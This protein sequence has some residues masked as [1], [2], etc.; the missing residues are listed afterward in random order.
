[1][2]PKK[3]RKNFSAKIGLFRNLRLF[4]TFVFCKKFT[5]NM[6]LI[7]V[8]T[9]CEAISLEASGFRLLSNTLIA[10]SVPYTCNQ[11][12]IWK[13]VTPLPLFL[14]FIFH[15]TLW[16]ISMQSISISKVPILIGFNGKRAKK[17]RCKSF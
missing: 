9:G 8:T 17:L 13:N 7:Q 6:W 5:F 2:G 3:I 1:M 4:Q 10:C 15:R 11:I 14:E 12:P 16:R